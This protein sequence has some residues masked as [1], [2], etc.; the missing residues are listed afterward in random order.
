MRFLPLERLNGL[1][2]S[3]P[4]DLVIEALRLAEPD[5]EVSDKLVSRLTRELTSESEA[6]KPLAQDVK[7]ET[8]DPATI[9]AFS[10]PVVIKALDLAGKV[11]GTVKESDTAATPPKQN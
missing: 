11:L 8:A 7:I 3:I 6:E 1:I 2:A 10:T 5:R 4:Q 9:A